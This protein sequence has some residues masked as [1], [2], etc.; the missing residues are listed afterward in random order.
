MK[1][2]SKHCA[3]LAS[4]LAGFLLLG[5]QAEAQNK[6]ATP[7]QPVK[8]AAAQPAS[9]SGPQPAP[10]TAAP[11]GPP[12]VVITQAQQK[13]LVSSV[14]NLQEAAKMARARK[15]PQA[16][17]A[18]TN[19]IKANPELGIAYAD[20][21]L[22]LLAMKRYSEAVADCNKAIS[23]RKDSSDVY[24]RR[25]AAYTQLKKYDLALADYTKIINMNPASAAAYRDRAVCYLRKGDK[26]NAKR[27]VDMA[28]K[29]MSGKIAG[30]NQQQKTS[31]LAVKGGNIVD[32]SSV[33]IEKFD[34]II[35]KDPVH[36][37]VYLLHRAATNLLQGKAQKA[38]DDVD[39]V[40]K[41]SDA[42]LNKG[43]CPSRD[44]VQQLRITALN[45][46]GRHSDVISESTNL[47]KSHPGDEQT[48]LILAM[49]NFESG[50]FKEA[51]VE[52]AKIKN[53][54]KLAQGAMIL[55]AKADAKLKRKPGK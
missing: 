27:D 42:D 43:G 25:A 14:R 38:L 24:N 3:I 44:K 18:Y 13:A 55:K 39:Q 52:A 51:S 8:E 36:K 48:R 1:I 34:E 33:P 19:L 21:A 6:T 41:L 29:A 49:S 23:L 35:K 50:K 16:Y 11:S 37:P 31:F 46:L 7:V 9:K 2:Q 53:N 17:G 5:W 47:L 20:R 12:K 32:L 28:K 15:W 40:L 22:T 30:T 4:S 26:K 54:P 10:Q 45:K